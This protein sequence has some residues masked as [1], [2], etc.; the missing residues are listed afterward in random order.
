MKNIEVEPVKL[1]N[2]GKVGLSW[3]LGYVS[4][5]KREN[6]KSIFSFCLVDINPNKISLKIAKLLPNT[7]PGLVSPL[8]SAL[9][10]KWLPCDCIL[11]HLSDLLSA[12]MLQTE[13]T[14]GCSVVSYDY[15]M[16]VYIY[17][18]KNNKKVERTKF[19]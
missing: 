14:G 9:P 2:L 16:L 10:D 1:G 3:A 7:E 12:L 8:L 19:N 13:W 17:K 5:W 11:S 18:K 4:Q 15:Q 6:L